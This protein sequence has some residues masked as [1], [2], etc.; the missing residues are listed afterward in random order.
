[1]IMLK[2]WTGFLAVV[3]LLVAGCAS[4]PQASPERDAE[5][6]QFFT[7]PNASTIYVYRNR[8]DRLEDDVVLFIDERLVGQILP[9]TYF[10]IDPVPRRHVL[11]GLGA[12]LGKIP[13]ETRAGEL[14]FV[15]LTVVGGHSHFRLVPEEV[16]RKR[17]LACCVL[18]ENWTPGQRPFLK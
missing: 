12:D 17:L 3:A 11:H 9:A 13:L 5:A 4:T 16:G 6:K 10:R 14:Y 8:F 1:M 15:E 2:I 18:L 7:H